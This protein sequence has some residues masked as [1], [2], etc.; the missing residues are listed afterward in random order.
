MAFLIAA[1]A[2]LC[3]CVSASPRIDDWGVDDPPCLSPY[4]QPLTTGPISAAPIIGVE[5]IPTP[6]IVEPPHGN[7]QP[8]H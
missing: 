6:I 8:G 1:S 7:P 4:N 2:A 3:G 5:P